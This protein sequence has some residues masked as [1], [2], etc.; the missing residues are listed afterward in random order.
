MRMDTHA[1]FP[2]VGESNHAIQKVGG[3]TK[4]SFL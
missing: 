4:I 2:A 3:I 1:L